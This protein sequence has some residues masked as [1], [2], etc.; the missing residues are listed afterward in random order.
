MPNIQVATG[1]KHEVIEAHRIWTRQLP[2]NAALLLESN[3]IGTV[4]GISLHIWCY[5]YNLERIHLAY[6]Q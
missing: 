2:K 1:Q 5:I 3:R 6:Q 4:I